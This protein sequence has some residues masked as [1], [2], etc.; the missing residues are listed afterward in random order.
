VQDL[1]RAGSGEASKEY[2]DDSFGDAMAEFKALLNGR[3]K[4][5]KGSTVLLTR[6]EKGTLG[7]IYD[8]AGIKDVIGFVKDERIGRQVFLNYLGGK[9][10]ASE[11]ARES[12]VEGLIE[13][14]ERPLGTV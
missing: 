5:P 13:L 4:T 9:S 3:G 14:V 7:F 11:K 10:I 8:H 12:I 1:S 6:D 2:E